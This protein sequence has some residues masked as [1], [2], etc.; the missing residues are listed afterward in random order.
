MTQIDWSNPKPDTAYSSFYT[1]DA[2]KDTI[3]NDD[4]K[5]HPMN[6]ERATVVLMDFWAH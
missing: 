5:F 6:R 2:E 3:I 1:N 4:E